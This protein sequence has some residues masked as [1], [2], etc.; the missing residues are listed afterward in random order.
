MK[1]VKEAKIR[2]IQRE[3]VKAEDNFR[4][5]TVYLGHARELLSLVSMGSVRNSQKR[6]C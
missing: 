6:E 2:E 1:V 3:L 4:K 5:A